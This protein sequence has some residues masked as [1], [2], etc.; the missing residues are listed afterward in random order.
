MSDDRYERGWERLQELAG[1]HG[2]GRERVIRAL[3]RN[4]QQMLQVLQLQHEMVI[5]T[6]APVGRPQA[7]CRRAHEGGVEGVGRDVDISGGDEA[8]KAEAAARPFDVAF[9]VSGT[10][11]GLASAIGVVRRGD[12]DLPDAMSGSRARPWRWWASSVRIG[13]TN[14]VFVSG[15][16]QNK[17]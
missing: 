16:N 10:A 17:P 15:S 3:C 14:P 1:E 11:A 5:E 13:S 9:E 4:V 2:V 7:G 6:A 12:W 8:L